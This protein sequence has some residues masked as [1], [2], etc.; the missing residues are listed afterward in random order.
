MIESEEN[1][2]LS[3]IIKKFM[4]FEKYH[5]IFY[6]SISLNDLKIAIKISIEKRDKKSYEFSNILHQG[7]KMDRFS[8][9]KYIFYLIMNRF[10]II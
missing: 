5:L 7:I 3:F 9:S 4:D 2:K 8:L 1:D 10:L 6:H